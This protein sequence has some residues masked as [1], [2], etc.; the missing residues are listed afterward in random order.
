VAQAQSYPVTY[1][2]TLL[3]DGVPANGVFRMRLQLYADASTPTVLASLETDVLV[4]QGTFSVEVGVLFANTVPP[5]MRSGRRGR[6][7]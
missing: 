5:V 3:Q 2:G 4:T 6:M 1:L 7:R